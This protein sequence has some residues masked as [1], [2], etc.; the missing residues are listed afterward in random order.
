MVTRKEITKQTIQHLS[1]R[2]GTQQALLVLHI[3]LEASGLNAALHCNRKGILL[4][5]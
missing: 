2:G 4:L 5:Q 3:E 1:E